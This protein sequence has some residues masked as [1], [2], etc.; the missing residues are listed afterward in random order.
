SSLSCSRT[1]E[2]G[3]A[4]ALLLYADGGENIMTEKEINDIVVKQ[5][6]YFQTGATLSVNTRISGLHRLYTAISQNEERIHDALRKDLG[7]SGFESY[8]CETGLVLEEISYM[9]KH[10]RR[11]SREKRVHTLLSQFPSRS[12]KKPL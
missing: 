10:I 12:Y 8:M 4:G 11:F 3:R 5:R 9:L 6:K 7:K 1:D 2:R